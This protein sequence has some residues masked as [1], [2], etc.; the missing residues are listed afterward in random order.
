MLHFS[1]P[2]LSALL[3][4]TLFFLIKIQIIKYAFEK[5]GIHHWSLFLLL[6][7]SLLGSYVNIPIWEIPPSFIYR[8]PV[9]SSTFWSWFTPPFFPA[10][11]TVAINLGGAIIPILI[12]FKLMT[13]APSPLKT[14]LVTFIVS[15]VVHAFAR[16]VPGAGITVPSVL[17]SLC[18][19]LCSLLIEGC[20]TAQTAYIA[21]SIGTLIGADLANL[22]RIAGLGIATVSIG[23]AGTFDGIFL[24]GI[25]AALL[26]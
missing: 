3:L 6:F 13:K 7:F 19:A 9:G 11:T 23:G 15:L 14:T 16:P 22:P 24:S 10:G 21:G 18:A 20:A 2:L 25:V 5:I 8:S 12:S 26:A 4:I 17:P 1:F